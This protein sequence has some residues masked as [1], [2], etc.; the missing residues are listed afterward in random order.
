MNPMDKVS[1]VRF[2]SPLLIGLLYAFIF[3]GIATVAVSLFVML[4][5]QS[6]DA[7]PGYA[8]GIH[9]AAVL[10]GSFAAGKRAGHKGWY[11]GGLIGLFYSL[12][13]WTVGFLSMNRGIDLRTAVF[14]GLGFTVGAIGG[15]VG[16]NAKK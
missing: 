13:V 15:I 14:V 16:V 5:D 9:A 8:Y 12:I 2:G 4:A 7:L 3:M 11:Y 1:Q 10:V 6:E